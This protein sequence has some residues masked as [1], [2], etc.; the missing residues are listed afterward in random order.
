MFSVL[1][2]RGSIIRHEKGGSRLDPLLLAA[3]SAFTESFLAGCFSTLTVDVAIMA[4][5]TRVKTELRERR[6]VCSLGRS[7]QIIAR[8]TSRQAR[9]RITKTLFICSVYPPR[10]ESQC[11][12]S[13][14]LSSLFAIHFPS[15]PHAAAAHDP[16]PR[17]GTISK[18]CGGRECGGLGEGRGG[19]GLGGQ[20]S[21]T[22]NT[23]MPARDNERA[24]AKMLGIL[25]P[26]VD[27]VGS[28]S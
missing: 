19:G 23:G 15:N 11:T 1:R 13:A 10:L 14:L 28:P 7:V 5:T 25:L 27:L 3:S 12:F 9:W 4:R 22:W 20:W 24:K 2:Q 21:Q 17:A 6:P 18:H 16:C 26:A 8:V